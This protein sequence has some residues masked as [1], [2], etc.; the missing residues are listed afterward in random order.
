MPMSVNASVKAI[1][2]FLYERYPDPYDALASHISNIR[3]ALEETLSIR[4]MELFSPLDNEGY[5]RVTINPNMVYIQE[6]RDIAPVPILEWIKDKR[7][8]VGN[9]I[10]D[11]T[12]VLKEFER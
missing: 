1:F 6:E 9:R 12:E 5:Y 3:T 4:D 11:L 2:A 8:T 10:K 7:I